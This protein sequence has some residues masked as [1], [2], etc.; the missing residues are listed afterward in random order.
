MKKILFIGDSITEWGK[1]QDPEDLGLGYVR[2][3]HDYLRVTYP[4][5]EFSVVNKGIGGNR[6]TDLANRWGKDVLEEKPDLV[7]ISIGVNDVWRQLDQPD[8]DQ[9]TPDMFAQ[10]YEGLLGQLHDVEVVLMEPTIIEEHVDA[11]GNQKL[12]A[13]VEIVRK[14]GDKYQAKVVPTHKAFLTYL[15][16]GSGVGLTTDGV[17]MNSKG[18]M[19]MAKTWLDAAGESCAKLLGAV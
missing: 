17:H 9:V 1:P 4:A 10:V 16:A 7:S 19:L 6:V 14:L 13:Y 2:L 5:A 3:V 12:S 11:V 15:Q 8:M 18:N